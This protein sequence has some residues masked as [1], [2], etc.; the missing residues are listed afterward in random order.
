MHVFMFRPRF[1]EP[2][3]AGTKTQTIRPQGNRRLVLPGD[4]LSLRHWQDKP[5]RSPHVQIA[6][7]VARPSEVIEV[8]VRG[9]THATSRQLK[10]VKDLDAFAVAD[11]FIDWDEMR[12]YW[13]EMHGRQRFLGVLYPWLPV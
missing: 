1:I 10:R 2:I 3:K 12:A 9:V 6:T 13:Q 5:Y 8:S 7:A 4:E 11:G